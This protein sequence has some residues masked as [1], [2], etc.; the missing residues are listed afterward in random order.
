MPRVA[1]GGVGG[2][3]CQG[4][5]IERDGTDGVGCEILCAFSGTGEWD[6]GQG[7]QE[8]APTTVGT[9]AWLPLRET[10]EAAVAT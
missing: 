1:R 8:L 5:A 4:G 10:A 7:R 9:A 3:R 2:G 6:S